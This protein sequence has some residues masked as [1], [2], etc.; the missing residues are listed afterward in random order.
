MRRAPPSVEAKLKLDLWRGI[1]GVVYAAIGVGIGAV[2][3]SA[4][5]V[6]ERRE[7][8][9]EERLARV[10]DQTLAAVRSQR[11]IDLPPE[12]DRILAFSLDIAGPPTVVVSGSYR[13]SKARENAGVGRID[14]F[15]AVLEQPAPSNFERVFGQ[16]P[17]YEVQTVFYFGGFDEKALVPAR[18]RTDDL[19]GDGKQELLFDLASDWGSGSSI[20]PVV[21]KRREQGWYPIVLPDL[22]DAATWPF[23]RSVVDGRIEF[24]RDLFKI[25]FDEFSRSPR[26]IPL[27]QLRLNDIEFGKERVPLFDLRQSGFYQLRCQQDDG[28]VQLVVSAA[29]EDGPTL[30]PHHIFGAVYRLDEDKWVPDSSWNDG[31]PTVSIDKRNLVSSEDLATIYDAA[32]PERQRIGR[33][34]TR[35]DVYGVELLNAGKCAR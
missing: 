32:V 9:A 10:S 26:K 8:S 22:S 15:L 34:L 3:A 7:P 30:G 4:F 27:S 31:Q 20:S 23:Y 29:Y 5:L 18:T 16:E 19:D 24:D 13:L 1:R 28:H 17:Q 21:L 25:S 35:G 33:P 6:L 2:I 12:I 14:K 11:A